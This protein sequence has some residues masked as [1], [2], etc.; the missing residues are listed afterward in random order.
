MNLYDY[1]NYIFEFKGDTES[2]KGHKQHKSQQL[3]QHKN[4]LK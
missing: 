2:D 1:L 4:K 3:Q